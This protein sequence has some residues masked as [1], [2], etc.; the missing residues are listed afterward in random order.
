MDHRYQIL[1]C[2]LLIFV[3]SSLRLV[4]LEADTPDAIQ[5][6]SMGLYVD[7]GYKTLSPRN[8]ILFGHTHWHPEDDYHGWMEMSPITNWSY[9]AS[10][11]VFGVRVGSA[12][13][14]TILAFFLFISAYALTTFGRY[15]ARI[16]FLGLIMLGL[17]NTLFF[18]S[19]IALIELPIILFLYLSIFA[20]RVWGT[21]RP[22]LGLFILTGG[23]LF[24]CFFVKLSAL[25]YFL[26]ALLGAFLAF[27]LQKNRSRQIKALPFMVLPAALMAVAVLI[28]LSNRIDFSPT[29]ILERLLVYPA[30]DTTPFLV[31]LGL[32]CAVGGLLTRSHL[33]T[34]NI[35]RCALLGIVLLSPIVLAFLPYHPL[36]YYV[37]ILP[38]A[39]AAVCPKF[40]TNS[41]TRTR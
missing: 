27:G 36:R 9:Y 33:Y 7:E 6:T 29:G 32:I 31:I 35:Y 37:P 14:V 41:M 10:F 16:F 1:L 30:L 20:L 8:L 38:A 15:P 4:H 25:A 18:F 5:S 11:R 39:M 24:T 17:E 22:L 3:L 28:R 13:V 2:I 19:R 26:P 40:L 12:R 34:Q 23:G 21:R